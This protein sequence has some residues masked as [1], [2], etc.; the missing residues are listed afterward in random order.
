MKL[1]SVRIAAL[2]ILAGLFSGTLTRADSP[3][4]ATGRLATALQPFV[5]DRTMAGAV[6]LVASKD[7]VLD[8]EAVGYADLAAKKPMAVDDMFWIASMSK[9]MTTR[10]DD[11]ARR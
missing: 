6:M 5:D 2:V 8:L 4:L 3:S 11:D 7:K 9:A 10:P 1:G